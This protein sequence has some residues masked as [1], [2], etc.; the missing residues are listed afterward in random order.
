[1]K[2]VKIA[3]SLVMM[4]PVFSGMNA[5]AQG[6]VIYQDTDATVVPYN[7][8]DSI[9]VRN[10]PEP[11][12]VVVYQSDGTSMDVP[13]SKLDSIVA[14]ESDQ[15]YW[16]SLGM[17][18]YTEDIV[19]TFFGVD[20]LTYEVEIQ[21]HS[22]MPGLYRLVNP[23]GAAYPYNEVGDYD[24]SADH[25]MVIDARD[26]EGVY[27]TQFNS[28]MDWGYG[29][30]IMWS[31][32]GYYM[33][34]G[35]DHETVKE[36][37]YCGTLEDGVITFP[38]NTLLV[39][40]TDYNN[41]AYYYSNGNGKF[42]VVFPGV[43]V[44]DYTVGV[45]YNN[46]D[47]IEGKSYA[48]ADIVLGGD[49]ESAK[50][51]MISGKDVDVAVVGIIDGSIESVEIE[52]DATLQFELAG[53][54]LYTIVAV[55]YAGGKAR[56]IGSASFRY[57]IAEAWKSLGTGLYTED[58]IAS[59]FQIENIT[60]EVEI[61]ENADKP[62]Y[63][64]LV[65]P[66]GAAYPYNEEGDYDTSMN[67]YLEIDATDPSAVYLPTMEQGLDWGYGMMSASSMAA[68]YMKNGYDL[69]YVKGEGLCG[70]LENGVI[71]FPAKALIVSFAD[72]N[73]GTL[74]GANPNGAFKVVLPSAVDAASAK[75][76]VAKG[77]TVNAASRSLSN[78]SLV[79][80]DG[81]FNRNIKA[82]PKR[83]EF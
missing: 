5:N 65:Y 11:G 48:V 58:L 43:V 47:S 2:L 50:V 1:M 7:K 16:V 6:V 42:K 41:G 39:A 24:T 75:G 59:Y 54:G 37:G 23:Y 51:A 30:F 14:Y 46:I 19:K 26:P 38:S 68:H 45:T 20:N 78:R 49:V 44:K 80:V 32:A 13:Y 79:K 77:V 64:R 73:S 71:T 61:Q 10:T 36:S 12:G 35:Y 53:D 22:L 72:Y 15:A 40:L 70:T 83:L 9:V 29:E 17:A 8:L 31:L 21:E 82:N 66:Y 62:G 28:G 4:F 57:E 3:L 55:S 63:Y 60:Y 33:E 74:L 56:E 67:Y 52:K 81:I 27:I 76:A 69:E 18:Q 34:K 25:Y